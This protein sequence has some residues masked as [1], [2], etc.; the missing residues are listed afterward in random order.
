MREHSEQLTWVQDSSRANR[1]MLYGDGMNPAP[2]V[3]Y[4]IR[5][6]EK[7]FKPPLSGARAGIG[8]R[9]LA[10]RSGSRVAEDGKHPAVVGV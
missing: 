6:A 5:H 3:I 10:R 9:L 1:V 4:V 2:E 8:Q 7:P